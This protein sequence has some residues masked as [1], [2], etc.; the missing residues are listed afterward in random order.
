MLI[1]KGSPQGYRAELFVMVSNYEQDRVNQELAGTCSDAASYCGIRD[2]LYPD[3]RAMGFPFDRVNRPGA[4][5]LAA[6]MTP[7]MRSQDVQ[8][9]HNDRVSGPQGQ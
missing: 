6:F 7:N 5:T 9:I 3:R 8:I 1:P 2:R 4:D